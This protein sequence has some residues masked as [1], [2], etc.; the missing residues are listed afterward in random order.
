MPT[1]RGINTDRNI[2]A[3]PIKNPTDNLHLM[4]RAL[5]HYSPHIRV[6]VPTTPTTIRR[7]YKIINPV[8]R[9][10][11][12]TPFLYSTRS[13]WSSLFSW[14][15]C[16]FCSACSSTYV[17]PYRD[18][19]TSGSDRSTQQARRNHKNTR[20]GTHTHRAAK[21]SQFSQSGVHYK[22][23]DDTT[24]YSVQCPSAARLI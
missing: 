2:N 14:R 22:Q 13:H 8:G 18:G 21:R 24:M 7:S 1:S 9:A 16:S 17:L 3:S 23:P 19:S 12:S 11:P 6:V 15:R 10:F 20:Q 4:P 5:H